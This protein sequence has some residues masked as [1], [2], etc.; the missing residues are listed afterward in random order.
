MSSIIEGMTKDLKTLPK[1][2]KTKAEGVDT[3][4]LVL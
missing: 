3:K 1:R 4:K 2:L